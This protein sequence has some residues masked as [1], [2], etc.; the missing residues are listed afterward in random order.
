VK[1]KLKN[2]GI[3][4]E[5]FDIKIPHAYKAQRKATEEEQVQELV[6]KSATFSASGIFMHTGSMLLTSDVLLSASRTV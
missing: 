1:I 3:N 5:I 4:H 6:K 2:E